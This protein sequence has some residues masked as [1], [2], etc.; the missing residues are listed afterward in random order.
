M[1]VIEH[2]RAI[3]AKTVRTYWA[4][5]KIVVPIA[6]LAQVLVATGMIDAI[7][8]FFEPLMQLYG[9]APELALAWLTG[10]FVGI[11]GAVVIVFT[12]VP[13]E[14]MSQA[15][16]TVLAALLLMV[17]ALPIEQRIVSQAGP[18]FW[19]T[20]A[21]RLGGGLIFAALLHLT[22]EMTGWLAAP[23]DPV[24]IPM[25]ESEGWGGFARG[26]LET[27]FWMFAILL[28]LNVVLETLRLSGVLDRI[29]HALAPF[30]GLAGIGA[31]GVPCS[32]IG[33]F[34]GLT[35]GGGM[36]VQEARSGTMPPRQIFI[37]CVFMGFAHGLIEDTLVFIALGADFTS[38]FVARLIFSVIASALIARRINRSP[39]AVFYRY[40]FRVRAAR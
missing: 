40:C 16:M 27:L 1:A 26:L 32:I 15:D 39:D 28:A 12:L 13:V 22:F 10:L 33:A 19:I 35:Y 9:L 36:I 3:L 30:F 5:I 18:G 14:A 24:W 34:L 6:V 23:V 8:P 29:T 31:S 25:S 17:H 4:L 21:I 2:A 38:I 11:W 37:V 7:S 20:T